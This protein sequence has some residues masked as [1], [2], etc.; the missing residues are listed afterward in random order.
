MYLHD[1][2]CGYDSC[3]Y[4]GAALEHIIL[5]KTLEARNQDYYFYV[6]DQNNNEIIYINEPCP[7]NR[8]SATQPYNSRGGQQLIIGI[9][10]CA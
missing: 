10:I 6:L 1:N 2:P 9:D 7:G 4:I 8:A 5:N 3:T